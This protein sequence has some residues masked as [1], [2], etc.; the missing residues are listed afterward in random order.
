MSARRGHPIFARVFARTSPAMDRDGVAEH[1][2]RLVTGL[3]GRVVEVGAGSGRNFPHYPPEVTA[4]LAV[5]PE[6][7]LRDIALRAAAEAPVR[8]EVVDGVAE[9]LPAAGAAFDAGVASLVLCSVADPAAA[10]R[11]LHR[12]IRPGGQLH[13]YEHVRADTPGLSRVQRVL[14]ATVWPLLVG[15]CHTWRDTGGAIEAAGFA[16]E[17]LD[18]LRYPETS[19]ALPTSPHILGTATRT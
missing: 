16:I 17:R 18:L 13:F 9:R 14:D 12:V 11:E 1:R 2:R 5:E 3:S 10:L 15:G 19:I 7:Y 6:R 8:I 4:V